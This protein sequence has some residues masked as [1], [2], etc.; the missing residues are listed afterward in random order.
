MTC[1]KKGMISSELMKVVDSLLCDKYRNK[2]TRKETIYQN[3][4]PLKEV[5]PDLE[6]K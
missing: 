6:Q 4:L 5:L 3:I 1:G 2:A